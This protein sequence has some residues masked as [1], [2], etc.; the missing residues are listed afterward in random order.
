MLLPVTNRQ[1]LPSQPVRPERQPQHEDIRAQQ[2]THAAV[3]LCGK[4]PRNTAHTRL[5]RYAQRPCPPFHCPERHR[6]KHP[7]RPVDGTHTKHRT[8]Q[9]RLSHNTHQ[10]KRHLPLWLTMER[11]DTMLPKHQSAPLCHHEDRTRHPQQHRK[12]FTRQSH[13]RPPAVMPVDEVG[14]DDIQQHYQ[15]ADKN[16]RDHTGLHPALSARQRSGIAM[17]QDH[18]HTPTVKDNVVTD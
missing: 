11:K 15:H 6:Q 4:P 1:H 16:N 10:R 18:N 3:R 2:R 17:P 14:Q 7:L 9:R 8:A 13:C 12:T 5:C